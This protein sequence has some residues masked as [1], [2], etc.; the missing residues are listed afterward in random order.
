MPPDWSFGPYK[1][2]A[3]YMNRYFSML[4]G[5]LFSSA[6][7]F[8][9]DTTHVISPEG[10]TRFSLFQK[11]DQL[12]FSVSY[13]GQKVVTASPLVALVGKQN[14]TRGVRLR[15]K[16]DYTTSRVYP[17]AGAHALARDRSNGARLTLRHGSDTWQLD[18]RVFDNG[19]AYRMIFPGKE[20]QWRIPDEA[21]TFNLPA[22]GTIWYHDMNMH[23]ESVHARKQVSQLSEGE[24]VAPPATIRFPSGV[25][26][27][28]TEADL[29]GYSGMSLQANGQNGLV[30]KLA[31]NQPTSYPYRLRYSPEDTQRLAKPAAIKGTITTPDRKSTRLNS[32][33]SR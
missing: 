25:Y 23:Y 11:N 2:I 22:D 28:I 17:M 9:A 13:K 18:V 4:S 7:L 3:N 6:M 16:K 32:S 15:G 12:H 27:A 33:H 30:L 29:K 10:A 8:A 26:A 21:T 5:L 1:N 19:A 14:L 20:G 31:H 24:W